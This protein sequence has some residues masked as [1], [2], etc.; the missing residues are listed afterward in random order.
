MKK[1]ETRET[2]VVR[3][4]NITDRAVEETL[5]FGLDLRGAWRSNLLEERSS[6][7]DLKSTRE[8]ELSL[9]PHEIATI[10]VEQGGSR[11]TKLAAGL[12]A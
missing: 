1:H 2:V 10:E 4:Y 7:L 9:G 12:V 3:L 6:G 5:R 11:L 8:V